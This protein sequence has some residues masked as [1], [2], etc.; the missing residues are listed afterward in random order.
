MADLLKPRKKT[1]VRDAFTCEKIGNELFST[2]IQYDDKYPFSGPHCLVR[3]TIDLIG[4]TV[5]CDLCLD[6]KVKHQMA[7]Y[8]LL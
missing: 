2:Q 3:H 1:S 7:I 6:R 5:D 8:D 4:S